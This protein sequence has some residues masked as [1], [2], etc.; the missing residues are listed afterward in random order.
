ME[1]VFYEKFAGQETNTQA[2]SFP[3]QNCL[4]WWTSMGL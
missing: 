4:D 1:E 3:R 2:P